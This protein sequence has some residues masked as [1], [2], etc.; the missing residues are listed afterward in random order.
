MNDELCIYIDRMAYLDS[1]EKQES[2]QL[3]WRN[4]AQTWDPVGAGTVIRVHI[5]LAIIILVHAHRLAVSYFD[6]KKM[7]QDLLP[8]HLSQCQ[9]QWTEA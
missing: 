2:R 6:S 9:C 1:L 4:L 8:S 3:L 7:T 5:I